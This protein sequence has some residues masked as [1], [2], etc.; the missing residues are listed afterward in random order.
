MMITRQSNISSKDHE[1]PNRLSG[2]VSMPATP[3]TNTF[4]GS[5]SI[6]K[7]PHMYVI[8]FQEIAIVNKTTRPFWSNTRYSIFSKTKLINKQFLVD[9]FSKL[10]NLLTY[11]HICMMHQ[12]TKIYEQKTKNINR[13]LYNKALIS[14][15]KTTCIRDAQV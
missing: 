8:S 15:A 3:V 12:N 10:S 4:I 11:I 2:W 9:F 14:D 6:F 1:K 13:N 5:F 7:E